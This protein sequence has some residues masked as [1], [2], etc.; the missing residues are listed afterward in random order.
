MATIVASLMATIGGD[1]SGLNKALGSA[2]GSLQNTAKEMGNF[3]GSVKNTI[4]QMAGLAIAG[5][6]AYK[7]VGG[8][9]DFFKTSVT[10]TMDYA[11]AV[12][13]VGRYT[14]TTADQASIF[15]QIADDL[16]IEMGTLKTG[17]RTLNKEG[18]QP[19]IE[20]IKKLAAEYQSI[21]DPVEKAQFAMEKF[22]AR[23]GQEM[24]KILELTAD[25]ID[26]IAESATNLG[27]VLDEDAIAKTEEYRLAVDTLN[28]AWKGVKTTMGM[29]IIPALA[30]MAV[31]VS[32]NIDEQ[33][34]WDK[35]MRLGIYTQ[36]ELF[37]KLKSGQDIYSI[38]REEITKLNAVGGDQTEAAF[39]RGQMAIRNAGSAAEDA[40]PAFGSLEGYISGVVGAMNEIATASGLVE[41]GLDAVAESQVEAQRMTTALALANGDL[42]KA[43]ME[44][45]ITQ[46][47]TLDNFQ[48][49]MPFLESGAV[50]FYDYADA[51][52]DGVLSQQDINSLLGTTS[53]ELG[54]IVPNADAASG[55]FEDMGS[56]AAAAADSATSAV[57]GV[58][59]SID[60]IT[61]AAGV[62][63]SAID[64]V[65]ASI[66]ALPTYTKLT[67]DVIY[68]VKGQPVGIGGGGEYYDE[69]GGNVFKAAGGPV[70]MGNAYIVGER[71]PEWFVP[72]TSGRI[73]PNAG[74]GGGGGMGGDTYIINNNSTGAAALTMAIIAQSHRARLSRSMGG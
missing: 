10:D 57:G 29:Q 63:A 58:T 49:L 15:L 64:G 17:F 50:N 9:V 33:A 37:A 40:G 52:K 66:N 28:D 24:A 51:V 60:G 68:N 18:I 16:Q 21:T 62:A 25:E 23:S 55:S 72:N 44:Q 74:G 7:A 27:L 4:K 69:R 59:E 11:K 45:L 26:N 8:V 54:D 42:T 39:A 48:K 43:E 3:G 5:G 36:D 70:A 61:S 12:R 65:G 35:V 34:M 20:N 2:K 71:G 47:T 53:E 1:A 13:D 32:E 46:Q 31:A 38:Y 22:G 19:N 14:G 41:M 30:D 73:V 56:R 67:I 6:I